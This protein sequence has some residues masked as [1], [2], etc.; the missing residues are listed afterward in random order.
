LRLLSPA[1]TALLFALA[2]AGALA[3]DAEK[4]KAENP[5]AD[6]PRTETIPVAALPPKND[7]TPADEDEIPEVII[8]ANKRRQNLR[9][10]PGSNAAI[11]GEELEARKAQGLADYIKLVPGVVLVDRGTDNGRPIIRGI[12]TSTASIGM[13]FTQLPVG[14]YVDDLPFTDLYVP[15][16]QPDLN[17]FDL[18]RVEILKGPQG[19]LFGSG[20]LAGAIRYILQKPKLDSWESKAS[21]TFLSNDQGEGLSPVYG[22]AQNIPLFGDKAA[23][24]LVGV[25]RENTGT[26]DELTNGLKDV[27]RLKSLTGR[28]LGRWDFN[29]R[30]T[31]NGVY[32]RQNTK[33]NNTPDSDNPRT[34][35]R[36]GQNNAIRKSEFAGSNLAANYRFDFADLLVTGSYL[37]KAVEFDVSGGTGIATPTVPFPPP[38][39]PIG[40]DPDGDGGANGPGTEEAGQTN[41]VR[42]FVSSET[43]GFFGETRLTS[44]VG[45]D[46]QPYSWLGVRYLAGAAYQNSNQRY[47]QST[48]VRA[49]D[50]LAVSLDGLP[51]LPLPTPVGPISGSR[52]TNVIYGD[53]TSNAQE[54]AIYAETTAILG[55]R[56]Q[57]ELTAGARLFQTKLHVTGFLAGL[58]ILALDAGRTQT[59]VDEKFEDG[60]INPKFSLRYL[61]NEHLQVFT[62]A[63]KGFQFGG[64]QFNPPVA[65]LRLGRPQSLVPFLSSK[66]WNY[67]VGFRTE[68]F[69]QRLKFDVT[70]FYLDWKDLQITVPR[71]LF[72]PVIP[73]AESLAL[74]VGFIENLGAA[75]S[76]GLESSFSVSPFRGLNFT[77]NTAFIYAVTTEDFESSSGF[78]PKGTR[79]PGSP[80]FQMANVLSYAAPFNLL[81]SWQ[82]ALSLTHSHI[83]SSF[84]NLQYTRAQGGYDTFD[85][86]VSLARLDDRFVPDITLGLNNIADVRGVAGVSGLPA[87]GR[88]FSYFLIPPRTLLLSL[89]LRF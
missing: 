55:S 77:S 63:A 54:P 28:A 2:S 1:I 22:A 24:R 40:G 17:P 87:G 51:G 8:T 53:L 81:G 31:L 18:E 9:D 60:G 83:G 32:F 75:R 82:G 69:D 10:V 46:W 42:A 52:D 58:E 13:E 14:I 36:S 20:A 76:T 61:I 4:S 50:D 65:A 78:V 37:Q 48:T 3:Q 23:L 71:P 11:S 35:E 86:N 41:L 68:F 26:I 30:L 70:G 59:D 89:G 34:F 66:L 74:T 6:A 67:E 15:F 84:F 64:I 80:R 45:D 72:L 79:L 88:D 27:D 57:L 33:Q 44:P 5:A 47:I 39:G 56:K 73:G 12:A 21:A 49:V 38:I 43:G 62:L 85:F 19:T 25:M 29:D 7:T 16:S